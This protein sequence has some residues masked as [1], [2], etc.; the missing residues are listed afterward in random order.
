MS[1]SSLLNDNVSLLKRNG[2]SVENIKASVQTDKIYIQRSDL[3]IESGDLIR[4]FA[5]NGAED[6][7][8]VI[9]P[10]FHEK[11][12]SIRAG[13]QM[14]V[15]KLGLPEAK[16]AVQNITYNVSGTNTRVNIN[17]V[18]SSVNIVK[19][20][21]TEIFDELREMLPRIDNEEERAIIATSIDSMEYT[22][23]NAEFL[24]QYQ[25]FVSVIANHVTVFGPWLAALAAML[26][27]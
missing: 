21:N 7:Y 5:S 3:L 4:R 13:Y 23:G 11:L 2:K 15:Q 8:E 18:D 25:N 17:S 27:S 22:Q 14:V 16:S 24:A 1:I 12:G 6:T 19:T 10:G 26:T 9:D 20:E